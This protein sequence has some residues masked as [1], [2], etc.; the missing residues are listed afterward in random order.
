[1]KN[2]DKGTAIENIVT[3]DSIEIHA[4]SQVKI[5]LYFLHCVMHG[6]YLI[7]HIYFVKDSNMKY[8]IRIFHVIVMK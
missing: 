4:K 6:I 2:Y 7:Y 1:M 8:S 5:T 3:S